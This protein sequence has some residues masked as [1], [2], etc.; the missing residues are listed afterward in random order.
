MLSTGDR[1]LYERYME[2]RDEFS[3]ISSNDPGARR[4]TKI[5]RFKQENELKLKLEVSSSTSHD[6]VLPNISAVPLQSPTRATRRRCRSPRDIPRRNPALY[7]PYLSCPRPNSARASN[8]GTNAAN[9]AC[10]PWRPGNGL[11]RTQRPAT[12]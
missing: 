8:P 1:K 11:S 10:R 5:A 7:P 4:D 2:N 12:R 3:L 9:T 6:K